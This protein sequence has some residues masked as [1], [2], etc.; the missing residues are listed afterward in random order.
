ML[1]CEW[2]I[3]LFLARQPLGQDL[4]I[5]EV[6]RSHTTARHSRQDSSRRVISPSQRLL[7]YNTQHSQQTNIHDPG[8]IRTHNLS[9]RAAADRAATVSGQPTDLATHSVASQR[10]LSTAVCASN[11]TQGHAS[12]MR[13]FEVECRGSGT[14]RELQLASAVLSVGDKQCGGYFGTEFMELLLAA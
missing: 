8:G 6:S 1:L 7:I 5:N 13:C 11:V 12:Q 9:R 2:F 14:S 4:L 10:T 3:C